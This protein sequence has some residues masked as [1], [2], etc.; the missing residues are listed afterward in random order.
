MY[1]DDPY[2]DELGI[3]WRSTERDLDQLAPRLEA[4]LRR[5]SFA[6]AA[7]F[8]LGFP[9]LCAGIALGAFTIWRGWTTETWN[10][11]T[12]GIAIVIISALLIRALAAFLPFRTHANSRTLSGM[13]DIATSRIGRTLFLIRTAIAASI[14]AAAFG[15]AGAVIRMRAGSPPHLSPII[16]LI[17]VALIIACLWLC[18][19]RTSTENRKLNYLRRTLGA[20]E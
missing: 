3:A 7:A 15:I 5:Q 20:N 6:I 12:R 11:V 14:I 2:W 17:I 4:R 19:R 13:L 8:A 1:P 9:L 16:D 10:F 18:E